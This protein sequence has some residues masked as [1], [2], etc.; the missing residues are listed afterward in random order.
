MANA[1]TGPCQVFDADGD[2]RPAGV[3]SMQR[4]VDA[5][6]AEVE[7]VCAAHPGCFTDGGALQSFVPTDEDVALDFNH[8]SIAGHRKYAEIAWKAF[9]DEIKKRP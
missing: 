1:G 4:I 8:L 2:P 7:S 6:W 9:P 5:Y 3:R